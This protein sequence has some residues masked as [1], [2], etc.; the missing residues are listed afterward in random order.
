MVLFVKYRQVM[1]KVSIGLNHVQSPTHHI[2]KEFSASCRS[3]TYLAIN[4]RL[5][6]SF[7][8][9]KEIHHGFKFMAEFGLQCIPKLQ[10]HAQFCILGGMVTMQNGVLLIN[11]YHV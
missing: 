6:P 1:R 10:S 2:P 5:N 7:T 3:S 4:P 8:L 11:N 9:N